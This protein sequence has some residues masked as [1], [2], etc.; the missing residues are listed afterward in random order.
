MTASALLVRLLFDGDQPSARAK[1]STQRLLGRLAPVMKL[2]WK[3]QQAAS[4]LKKQWYDIYG[5]YYT[6]YAFHRLGGK[7]WQAWG[8]IVESAL[9]STQERKGHAA[10]SF[11]FR[12]RGGRLYATAL[13]TLTLEAYYRHKA[14]TGGKKLVG[15]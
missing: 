10:G 9:A 3:P 6:T 4:A 2:S 11:S 15:R 14:A 7:T 8:P 1:L 13:N 12:G 5:W